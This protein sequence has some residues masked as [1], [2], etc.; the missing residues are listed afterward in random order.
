GSLGRGWS[1]NWDVS[2][3]TLSN[4][5]VV[6]H[7]PGGVD[8]FFTKNPNGSYTGG[9]GD[10]GVLTLN[11]GFYDLVETDQTHWHFRAHGL[12]NYVQDTD[13]NR[14]TLGYTGALLTSLTHSSGQQLLLAYNS[15]GR[16]ISVTNP[17][18]PGTA[19]DLVTTYQYD[20]SGE[21]LLH[22]IAPGN[23]VTD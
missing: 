13:G 12:L 14:I 18:G 3:Q 22:V 15:A 10:H 7:G 17:A 1:T 5:D 21:H 16:L 19:D 20:A 4:G 23:R 6:L 8:R 9:I 2:A 11:D